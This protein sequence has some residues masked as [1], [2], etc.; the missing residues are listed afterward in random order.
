MIQI[1]KNLFLIETDPLPTCC[2]D[3]REA[4]ETMGLTEDA[5]C[6]NCDFALLRWKIE[7]T[8]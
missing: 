6:Y 1:E 3:C 7:K 4:E 8:T 2:V 5:Y